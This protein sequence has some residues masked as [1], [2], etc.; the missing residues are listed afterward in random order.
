MDATVCRIVRR[1]VRQNGFTE[2]LAD[3]AKA[4]VLECMKGAMAWAFLHEAVFKT[5]VKS[6]LDPFEVP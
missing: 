1:I 6:G 3:L 5:S 2:I 4:I